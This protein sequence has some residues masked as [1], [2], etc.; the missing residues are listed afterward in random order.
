[1]GLITRWPLKAQTRPLLEYEPVILV[2][3]CWEDNQVSRHGVLSLTDFQLSKPIFIQQDRLCYVRQS[4][5]SVKFLWPDKSW[6]WHDK[7]NTR[8]MPSHLTAG[9]L[10]WNEP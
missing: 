9:K 8:L 6:S 1:M 3:G 5:S 4:I 2:G 10:I 7:C